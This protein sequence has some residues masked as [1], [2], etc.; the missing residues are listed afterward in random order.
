MP[1]DVTAERT[2]AQVPRRLVGAYLA[3]KIALMEEVI[4]ADATPTQKHKAEG[5]ATQAA[6][7]ERRLKCVA[8]A[9]WE[10][11]LRDATPE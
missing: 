10:A 1:E 2:A 6:V 4:A 3:A 8:Q 11:L 9:V 5:L 7:L